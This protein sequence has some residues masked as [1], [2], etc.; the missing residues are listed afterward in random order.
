MR[1]WADDYGTSLA[2]Q[3]LTPS[4]V[5]KKV[6]EGVKKEFP[7]KFTNPNKNNAPSV[8]SG[9]Q[10]AAGSKKDDIELSDQERKI[11]NTLVSTKVMTKDEY[12][13]Q[14]KAVKGIK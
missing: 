12:L 2:G 11:M 4:E 9:S 7:Q 10:K 14:L 5:L 8:E 6:E 1:K 3:G 13:K